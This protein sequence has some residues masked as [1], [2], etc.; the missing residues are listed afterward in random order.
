MREMDPST[1]ASAKPLRCEPAGQE[2]VLRKS[3]FSYSAVKS[4]QP[5]TLVDL[6]AK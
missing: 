2:T 6:D 4:T 5:A 3:A 1:L